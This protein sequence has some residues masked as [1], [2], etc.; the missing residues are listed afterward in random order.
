[1]SSLD[2]VVAELYKRLQRP[3]TKWPKLVSLGCIRRHALAWPPTVTS[4]RDKP[5]IEVGRLVQSRSI[6]KYIRTDEQLITKRGGSNVLRRDLQCSR[7]DIENGNVGLLVLTVFGKRRGSSKEDHTSRV[8]SGSRRDFHSDLNGGCNKKHVVLEEQRS[9]INLESS[10]GR[11]EQAQNH[12][13][14]EGSVRIVS[15]T[16]SER[17]LSTSQLC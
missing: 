11:H 10:C 13:P 16:E 6:F 12:M 15:Q 8:K 4:I 17:T 3:W 9:L 5:E 7:H 14:D 1:M 2:R